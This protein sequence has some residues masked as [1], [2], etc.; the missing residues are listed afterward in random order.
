[1]L[2]ERLATLRASGRRALVCYV[3]A[4]HPDRAG[5][6]RLLRELPAAGADV[7]EVGVP[8]SDPLADGP[9]IQRA[10]ERALEPIGNGLQ[11]I[12]G[13]GALEDENDRLRDQ[14]AE[15]TGDGARYEQLLAENAQLR[16]ITGVLD[17][18]A[19]YQPLGARVVAAQRLDHVADEFDPHRF[20]I[21]RG[22]QIDDASADGE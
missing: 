16:E 22:E 2:S 3:T 9:V 8:F 4:G 15:R 12:T 17:E 1:M 21:C 19:A 13:Y 20:G 14:L 10:T 5:S 6:L 7:I 11:G 18:L